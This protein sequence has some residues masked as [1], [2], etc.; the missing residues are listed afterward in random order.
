M[1]FPKQVGMTVTEGR[2]LYCVADTTDQKE[3][4]LPGLRGNKVYLA[5]FK[6]ISAVIS[7]VPFREMSTNVEDLMAHQEVVAEVRKS[8]TVLPIRF[9][10]I[11]R[12]DENVVRLLSNSYQEYRNK[13]SKF[14][15]K[16]EFGIKML[17]GKEN[18]TAIE[19]MAIEQSEEIKSLR[20]QIAAAGGRGASYF[21][22]MK[23]DDA[24]K[25]QTY[26]VI[27]SL[28]S[29]VNAKLKAASEEQSLLK[30]DLAQI[31]FNASYLVGSENAEKFKSVVS[32]LQESYRSSYGIEIHL[33]GPWAPYSF[34]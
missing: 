23:L 8:A 4:R 18:R 12:N 2:Y 31:I 6:D 33:S 7:A 26:R 10:V 28:V 11:L 22:R 1:S 34:C 30:S 17:L 24:K 15:G 29:E 25:N 21:L 27:D 20:E 19:K 13:L 32:E 14:R 5:S 16:D 9:G 3:I